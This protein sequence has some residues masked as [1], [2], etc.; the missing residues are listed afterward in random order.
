M[1]NLKNLGFDKRKFM[2]FFKVK[3]GRFTVDLLELVRVLSTKR[4][5]RFH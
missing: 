5:D 1:G 2:L 3:I 4:A